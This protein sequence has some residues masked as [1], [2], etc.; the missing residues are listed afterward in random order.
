MIG[1]LLAENTVEVFN[2]FLTPDIEKSNLVRINALKTV[3]T[4][5]KFDKH[6]LFAN[7]P[8]TE[9]DKTNFCK[10]PKEVLLNQKSCICDH[11]ETQ[12]FSPSRRYTNLGSIHFTVIKT[13]FL[14][15]TFIFS[16]GTKLK[17]SSP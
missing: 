15:C 13:E 16:Y 1:Q 4:S 10:N 3:K 14:S 2:V 12:Q 17:I 9:G 5:A 7:T 11:K 6:N 8:I